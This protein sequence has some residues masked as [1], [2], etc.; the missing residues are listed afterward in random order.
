MNIKQVSLLTTMICV[1]FTQHVQAS[2]I[3]SRDS[4]IN[5]C[6]ASIKPVDTSV[7]EDI[8]EYTTDEFKKIAQSELDLENSSSIASSVR[9][10]RNFFQKFSLIVLSIFAF[11]ISFASITNTVL[12]Q[13]D[14]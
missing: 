1:G 14:V 12:G 6:C 7:K 8:R 2:L 13:L 5:G 10:S 9:R 3:T 4:Y 11:Y